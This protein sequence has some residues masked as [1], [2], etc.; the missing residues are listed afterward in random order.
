MTAFPEH[1]EIQ[2]VE[3]GMAGLFPIDLPQHWSQDGSICDG[4]LV[5]KP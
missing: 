5:L 1:A 2:R 3:R 4:R